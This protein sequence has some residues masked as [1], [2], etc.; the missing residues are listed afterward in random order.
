MSASSPTPPNTGASDSALGDGTAAR[1]SQ[2]WNIPNALS[3]LRLVGVPLFLW[4]LLVPK[5]DVAAVVVLA[6]SGITD[7]L[8]GKL[9]RA[10]GQV[11]RLGQLLDP[12]ADRLYIFSTLVAF[13]ARG[14]I[15][16]WLAIG[17][18][19]RDALLAVAMLALLRRGFNP[20]EVNFVG[21]TAT[22]SLLY[23]FPLLLLVT[24]VHS[25]TTLLSPLAWGFAIWGIGLYWL[26]GLLYIVQTFLLITRRKD[27]SREHT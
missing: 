8:D 10:L 2:I 9:A 24:A 6:I 17:L 3:A 18:I 25:V 22:L 15:P 20:P 1:G 21:K 13:L 11:T 26:A 23:A 7:W 14:I 5:A 4:L 16:P 19:A 12:I 27:T